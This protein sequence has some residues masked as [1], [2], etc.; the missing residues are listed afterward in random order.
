MID[1]NE[2][3]QLARVAAELGGKAALAYFE[4]GVAVEKKTDA[5]PVT[6]ADRAADD[7][8]RAYLEAHYKTHDFLSE[9]SGSTARQ[10]PYRWIIDPLDGTKSFIRGLPFWG[11]LVALEH[12]GRV[13]AGAVAMPVLDECYW[14]AA[15]LGCHGKQGRC[16]VS[17]VDRLEEATLSLGELPRLMR[18]PGAKGLAALITTAQNVRC[19]GDVAAPVLLVS[20]RADVWLEAG[21]RHWDLAAHQILIEEAGGRFSD[22]SGNAVATSGHALGSNRYLH[23]RALA[24]LTA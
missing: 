19:F 2:A 5:T 17:N 12:R 14:A 24:M 20:G 10:S 3:M 22:F 15:G 1:L 21:V 11:P 6:A 16:R 4:S 13:V 7:A 8:I 18:D 9:E 23:E